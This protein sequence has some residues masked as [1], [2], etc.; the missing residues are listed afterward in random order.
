MKS[1]REIA[2]LSGVS[3]ASISRYMNKKGNVSESTIAKIEAVLAENEYHPNKL[4]TAIIKGRSCD[5]ALI[6]QN[7]MNPFF[8]QLVDEI[9]L[10]IEDT[11]YNLIICNC[12]GNADKER[13]YYKNLL[14]KRIAGILVINTNDEAIYSN[15]TVPIIGIEKRVLDFPKVAISN[16]SALNKIFNNVNMQNVHTLLIKGQDNNHSSTLR[17]KYYKALAKQNKCTYDIL[18][19]SDNMEKLNDVYSIDYSIYDT[20]VCWSD[21]VAHKIYGDIVDQGLTVPEDI[22]LI[23]FD[24][25]TINGIFSYQLTT[26]DQQIGNIGNVAINNLINSINGNKVED[27]YLDPI[28]VKGNTTR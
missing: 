24:G 12:K 14:E 16:K 5:I 18:E 6:V 7:I 21:I 19:V 3:T 8:A 1:I 26:I 15:K 9:E 20:V 13:A 27:I 11:E 10:L 17:T 28:F 4:T 23:G 25:L 2:K 22:Q